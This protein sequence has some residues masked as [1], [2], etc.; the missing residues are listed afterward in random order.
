MNR[1]TVLKLLGT[2][3]AV[4][5]ARR[6]A[7]QRLQFYVAGARFHGPARD[8][9]R[10]SL[11]PTQFRGEAAIAVHEPRGE[12]I[13]WVPSTLVA[14]ISARHATEARVIELALDGVP[15]RWYRVEV[16]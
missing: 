15:W 4:V 1:R 8:I 13:G 9:E 2:L 14:P 12:Q 6:P 7:H 3:V 10:V 11:R 5:I 16:S